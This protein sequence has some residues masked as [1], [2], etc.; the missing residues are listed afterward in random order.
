[1]ADKDKDKQYKYRQEIQQLDPHRATIHLIHNSRQVSQ[2]RNHEASFWNRRVDREGGHIFPRARPHASCA[3]FNTHSAVTIGE[4]II[5]SSAVK[6]TEEDG[7]SEQSHPSDLTRKAS[8]QVL[9][10][11]AATGLHHGKSEITI[12]HHYTA[13]HSGTALATTSEQPLQDLEPL[14]SG[15]SVS[16][17]PQTLSVF[18]HSSGPNMEEDQPLSIPSSVSMSIRNGPDSLPSA[19]VP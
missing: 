2:S 12:R 9:R 1:M 5:Y 17:R 4:A 16:D 6:K 18:Q 19:Y 15:P 3:A 10:P 14:Q 11:T 13:T 7:F 8:Y